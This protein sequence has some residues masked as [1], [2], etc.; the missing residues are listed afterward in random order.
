MS[1][2]SDGY[3]GD[4]RQLRDQS[5]II[6][7]IGEDVGLHGPLIRHA[8][9]SAAAVA[10]D[11]ELSDAIRT[12]TSHVEAAAELTSGNLRRMW[13]LGHRQASSLLQTF[14]EDDA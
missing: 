4:P 6:R 10:G 1:V 11:P 8:G 3:F 7:R 14:G 9:F 12:A 5:R 13:Q 2:T